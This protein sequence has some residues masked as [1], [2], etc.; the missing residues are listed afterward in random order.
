MYLLWLVGEKK[1]RTN[2]KF[3]VMSSDILD[4]QYAEYINLQSLSVLLLK[5]CSA[6][7][8]IILLY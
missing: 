5:L 4:F 7:M 6:I 8:G 1:I 2:F 3:F